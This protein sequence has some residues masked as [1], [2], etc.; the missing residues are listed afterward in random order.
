MFFVCI[1]I[2]VKGDMFYSLLDTDEGI[3][4]N[5]DFLMRILKA[6]PGGDV[7]SA[8][9]H[10]GGCALAKDPSWEMLV[11]FARKRRSRSLRKVGRILRLMARTV[12]TLRRLV[13]F[14]KKIIIISEIFDSQLLC[15]GAYG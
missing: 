6:T 4:H 9:N 3:F 5:R 10:G 7:V 12:S 14:K 2:Q 8:G 1:M 11:P 13:F 15:L